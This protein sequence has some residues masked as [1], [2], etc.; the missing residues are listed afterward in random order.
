MLLNSMEPVGKC[1]SDAKVDNAQIQ[2]MVFVSRLTRIPI[3]QQLLKDC[4]N[5]KKINVSINLDDDMSYGAQF[6]M[7]S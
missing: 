4:F 5:E 3:I 1:L 6:Y 2:K 7:Q